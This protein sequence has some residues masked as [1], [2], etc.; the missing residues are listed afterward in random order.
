MPEVDPDKV[1]EEAQQAYGEGNEKLS[2]I[3]LGPQLQSLSSCDICG[4][5]F[6]KFLAAISTGC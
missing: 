3:F 6:V 2:N 5:L 1:E 4:G